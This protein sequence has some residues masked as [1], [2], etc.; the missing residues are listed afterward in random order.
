MRVNG[1]DFI[2]AKIYE[3]YVPRRFVLDDGSI[4][5]TFSSDVEKILIKKPMFLL[6]VPPSRIDGLHNYL[7]EHMG[8]EE[9]TPALPKG[10]K[11]TVRKI[12]SYPWEHHLRFFE[13]GFIEPEIEVQREFFQHL[14]ERR[15]FIIYEAFE[16]YRG[17]YESLHIFHKP[18]GKWLINVSDHFKLKLKPPQSLTSWKP[19]VA[20]AGVALTVGVLLYALSKLSKGGEDD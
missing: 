10:E 17:F 5:S 3:T 6:Y 15:L 18:T 1:K 4:V 19:V 11:Y 20:V 7:R 13:N 8:F 14:G 9:A 2:R 12:L 16:Y